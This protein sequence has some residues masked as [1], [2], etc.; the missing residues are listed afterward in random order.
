MAEANTWGDVA[1]ISGKLV[2][3]RHGQTAWSV[4]GQH[5][6]RTDIPLT[7]EGEVQAVGAGERLRNAIPGGFSEGC[8]F[9]SPLSRARKTA[10]LAGFSQH[11]VLDDLA[12]WDYGR[13]EG[14]TRAQLA[15][16]LGESWNLWAD[17]TGCLPKQL[18][19]EWDT[20]LPDGTAVHVRNGR[21]EEVGDVAQRAMRAVQQ[22]LPML[23]SGE[24]VLFVAH[25][26]VLRVVATQWLDMSP[27]YARQLRMDT[28][29]YGVLGQY[30]GDAVI[31][32]WNC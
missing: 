10:M 31:E 27:R 26:H 4:S 11:R 8:V 28:A 24:N 9:S 12:E 29:H 15:E 30:K 21:G 23:E 2:L 32:C 6:G 3:L 16:A 5:T 17:G 25:A 14:R 13:A 18:E 20:E 1:S 7:A 19:G 22:V